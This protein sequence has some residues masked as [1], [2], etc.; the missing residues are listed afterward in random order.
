[1]LFTNSKTNIILGGAVAILTAIFGQ[2]WFLFAGLMVFNVIDWIT[3]TYYA[4]LK[5]IDNSRIGA[6]G[7]IKKLGCWVV[8]FIAFYIGIC[9]SKMGV[10]LGVNLNFTVGIGWFVLANYIVNELR[11][12]LENMLK[13]GWNVP[14]F[15]VK[16]LEAADKVLEEVTE[17]GGKN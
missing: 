4:R 5:H 11:S 17:S 1:M 2:Y 14:S 16:G 8:I 13:L 15:L 9:F 6:Q 12:I 10:M 3:G 7:T